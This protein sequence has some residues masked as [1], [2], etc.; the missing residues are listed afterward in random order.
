MPFLFN[1]PNRKIL[2]QRLRKKPSEPERILWRSLKGRQLG[3][4]KFRRQVSVGSYIV[5][6][7]SFEKRLVIEL[8][9]DTHYAS[10]E[11]RNYDER[12]TAF[13]ERQGLTV[14]RFLNHQVRENLEGCLEVILKHLEDTPSGSPPR[15]GR[16]NSDM[17][18]PPLL[19]EAGRGN[20]KDRFF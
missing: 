11:A 8:D 18:A 15:R 12:R 19:G 2:R 3:G 10:E 7:Y 9:G 4:T 5:D 1:D 6:F 14:L 13:L 20:S 16:E 17:I